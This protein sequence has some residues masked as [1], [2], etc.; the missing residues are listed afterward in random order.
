MQEEEALVGREV[1][2]RTQEGKRV[3][4]SQLREKIELD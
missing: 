3:A 2:K 1:S 4:E